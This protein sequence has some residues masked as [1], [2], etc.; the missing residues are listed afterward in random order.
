M[1]CLTKKTEYALIALASLGQATG[2][3]A[4]ARDIA[5]EHELPPALLMNIL[6]SLQHRNV[7]CSTRGA[8]GGYTLGSGVE[9]LSLYD[10]ILILE[11]RVQT[12]GC[13][14]HGEHDESLPPAAIR[15]IEAPVRALQ[16]RLTR[17]LK[18]VRVVDLIMPGR[19]IDVPAELVGLRRVKKSKMVK[20]TESQTDQQTS[21]LN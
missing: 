3:V 18:E 17:F 11:G 1:L 8:R 16:F 10:L 13:E 9:A 5:L 19:R 12:T 6:K 2:E 21:V 14:D 4:S 15:A 20:A 7:V